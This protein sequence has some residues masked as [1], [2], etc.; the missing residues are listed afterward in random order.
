[1]HAK[2]YKVLLKV[3][4]YTSYINNESPIEAHKLM[5]YIYF[6]NTVLFEEVLI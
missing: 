3:I 6:L 4:A 2:L 5:K 1:M